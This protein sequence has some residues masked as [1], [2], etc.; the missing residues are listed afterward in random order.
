MERLPIW[1]QGKKKKHDSFPDKKTTAYNEKSL[2]IQTCD[3][4]AEK[5]PHP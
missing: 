1:S 5:S 2:S 3:C 4:R